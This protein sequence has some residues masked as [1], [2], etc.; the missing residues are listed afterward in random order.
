MEDTKHSIKLSLLIQE[1]YMMKQIKHQRWWRQW[2]K[3]AL[4]WLIIIY[5]VSRSR[6]ML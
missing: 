6:G 4:F 3:Q 1:T 5:V 2:F